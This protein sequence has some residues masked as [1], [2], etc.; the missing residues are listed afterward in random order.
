VSEDADV[1]ASDDEG[2]VVT[3]ADGELFVLRAIL[4]CSGRASANRV[5]VRIRIA[6]LM[7][8]CDVCIITI[9]EEGG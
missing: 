5:F 9:Q 7:C 2:S 3:V 4:C 6:V 1:V 8:W